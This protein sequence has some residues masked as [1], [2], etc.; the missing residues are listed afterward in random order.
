MMLICSKHILHYHSGNYWN[1]CIVLLFGSSI[2]CQL[3]SFDVFYF[4]FLFQWSL[5]NLYFVGAILHVYIYIFYIYIYTWYLYFCYFIRRLYLYHLESRWRN[6]HVLVYQSLLLSHLLGVAPSTFT[7]VYF[8]WWRAGG[9]VGGIQRCFIKRPPETNPRKKN[10]KIGYLGG[11][12]KYF[13]FPS[14][15]GE[16]SHFDY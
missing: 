9:F 1:M 8:F 10:V 16:D 6:S 13:S 15:P 12:F 3:L 7:M 14:L 11:G 2:L 5:I 4:N